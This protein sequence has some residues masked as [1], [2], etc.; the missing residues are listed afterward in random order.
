MTRLWYFCISAT[1]LWRA[2]LQCKD[3]VKF[4]DV[5]SNRRVEMTVM[6]APETDVAPLPPDEYGTEVLCASW[7]PAASVVAES[8]AH[9]MR[10]APGELSAGEAES[11]LHQFYRCDGS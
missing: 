5:N 3:F 8:R 10:E 2:R 11:F 9:A 1:F 6:D 7:N 4:R